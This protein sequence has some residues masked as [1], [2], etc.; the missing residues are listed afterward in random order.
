MKLSPNFTLEELCT[1][2]TGMLNVPGPMETERLLMLANFILQPVRSRFGKIGINSGFRS[3]AVNK[4]IGGSP[5]SQHQE[6]GA[7]DI[8]PGDADIR[9]VYAWM[10]NNLRFGQLIFEQK[11]GA[12]WIHVSLPRLGKKNMMVGIFDGLQYLWTSEGV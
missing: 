1:T 3:A 12:E 9:E 10:K 11:D 4:A 8:K 5:T 6:G 7:A 2:S